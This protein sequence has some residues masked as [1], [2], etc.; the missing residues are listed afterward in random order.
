MKLG[1][2]I[3]AAALAACASPSTNTAVPAQTASARIAND[4]AQSIR[5][6]AEA[7]TRY[8]A[9]HPEVARLEAAQASLMRSGHEV[10]ARFDDD[11]REAVKYQLAIAQREGA[12]MA[13]RYSA[14]HPERVKNAA[15]IEALKD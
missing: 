1:Y 9:V 2:L 13:L 6:L 3:I 14:S 7:R 11:L 15:V 8:G 12:E 5:Q 4:V 10:N